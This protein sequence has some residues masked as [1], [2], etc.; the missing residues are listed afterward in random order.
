MSNQITLT[1]K[2]SRILRFSQ[3]ARIHSFIL[4]WAVLCPLPNVCAQN[5][6]SSTNSIASSSQIPRARGR[7]SEH[8]LLLKQDDP[9]G[10][11]ESERLVELH[12]SLPSEKFPAP[13]IL[14]LSQFGGD[15]QSFDYLREYWAEQGFACIFLFHRDGVDRKLTELPLAERIQTYQKI[16]NSQTRHSRSKDVM[17]S[18]TTL[19]LWSSSPDHSLYGQFDW[20]RFG[21]AGHGFGADVALDVL[22][23]ISTRKIVA[24]NALCVIGPTPLSTNEQKQLASLPCLP[25]LILSGDLDESLIRRPDPLWRNHWFA[26]YPECADRFELR[27][28][29]GKHFDFTNTPLRFGRPDRNP[30]YHPLIQKITTSFFRTY[31]DANAEARQGLE[32]PEIPLEVRSTVRWSASRVGRALRERVESRE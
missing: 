13:T 23:E 27:F 5:S 15:I 7:V 6:E 32:D 4:C 25:G 31:L 28:L 8:T 26:S 29:D 11:A 20:N 19:Q 3:V 17:D 22:T 18:V 10:I 21:I 2:A 30:Y 12:I 24:P 14:F 16:A 1:T 9:N